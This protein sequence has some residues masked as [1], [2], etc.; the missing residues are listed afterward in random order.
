MVSFHVLFYP[1]RVFAAD[2]NDRYLGVVKEKEEKLPDVPNFAAPVEDAIKRDPS[3]V[4]LEDLPADVPVEEYV[5]GPPQSKRMYIYERPTLKSLANLFWALGYADLENDDHIDNYLKL[6]ECS[7]YKKFITSEFE[8]SE[9][10]SATRDFIKKSMSDFPLRFEL[11][12]EIFF[13]DYDLKRKAFKVAPRYQIQTVRRFEMF[14]TDDVLKSRCGHS[15]KLMSGFPYGTVI[16]VSR[17]VNLTYVPTPPDVAAVYMEEKNKIF[18]KFSDKSKNKKRLY[19][20]RNGYLVMNMKIF[21][22]R[23]KI[24][25]TI[26]G[27][28][29]LLT[30]GVLE[31]YE[32]YGDIGRKELFYSQ[33]FLTRK[34]HKEAT[35]K[36]Q[37]EFEI[38]IKK[39]EGEGML[40]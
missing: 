24:V 3:V 27:Y 10:R 16:E 30:M 11:V 25:K 15:S 22:H 23:G 31:G 5:D 6:T 35:A 26:G 37:K 17:P 12:Q 36:L 39:S 40:H 14:T 18:Q 8:W 28:D 13:T 2:K 32:I 9:I 19:E 38:L 21:A 4:Q 1:A 7:I 33:S 34:D 29:L 20:L